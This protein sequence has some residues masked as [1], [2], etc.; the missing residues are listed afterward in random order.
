MPGRPSPHSLLKSVHTLKAASNLVANSRH[1][2]RVAPNPPQSVTLAL[3]KRF[4]TTSAPPVPPPVDVVKETNVSDLESVLQDDRSKVWNTYNDLVNASGFQGL[5][6]EVHQEVLR[7]CTRPAPDARTHASRQDIDGGSLAIPHCHEARFQAVIRNIRGAGYIPS[8]DDYHFVLSQFAAVGNFPGSM[9]VYK[10]LQT[11]GHVPT[12]RTFGYILQAIAR[13][14]DLPIHRASR[15]AMLAKTNIVFNGLLKDMK[16]LDIPTVPANIDLS[17]RIL[18]ESMNY[19]A[20]ERFMRWAYGIDMSYPDRVPLD[21][22]E[23]KSTSDTQKLPV[24]FS[25]HALNTTIDYLGRAG[26]LSKMIQAFEVLT[27]PLPLAQEHFFSSFE[28]DEDDIGAVLPNPQPKSKLPHALPNTTT[29]SILIRHSAR[30]KHHTLARHYLNEAI[31]LNQEVALDLRAT[32]HLDDHQVA[33]PRFSLQKDHFTSAVNLGV[34]G[35]NKMFLEWVMRKLPKQIKRKDAELKWHI[36]RRDHRAHQ[37][38]KVAKAASRL[39]ESSPPT[40]STFPA[41]LDLDF[42]TSSPPEPLSKP[43]D[44][45]LHIRILARD[46]EQLTQLNERL[47]YVSGRVHQRTKERLGRRVWEGKDVYVTHKGDRE[48]VSKLKWM[49]I[50]NF[51]PREIQPEEKEAQERREKEEMLADQGNDFFTPSLS[52]QEVKKLPRKQKRAL[53]A[54]SNPSSARVRLT[55]PEPPSAPAS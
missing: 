19:T 43:F 54:S 27:Q 23:R 2:R 41:N 49:H 28:D 26:N 46:L 4:I 40:S 20:F 39:A 30:N 6:L 25:T 38:A 24:P 48:K 51:K 5:P 33:Q 9:E 34:V 12:A 11:V 32:K 36:M 10:E 16:K 29:Y 21:L 47:R 3:P 17:F 42:D 1:V 50:M 15:E 53:R 55:P 7:K 45:A 37:A 52:G 35:Q 18:K 13:R 31:W 14:L 44:S 22:A 8:L